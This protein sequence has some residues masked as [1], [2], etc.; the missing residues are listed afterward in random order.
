IETPADAAIRRMR[1]LAGQRTSRRPAIPLHVLAGA[2]AAMLV[3][4]LLVWL[5]VVLRTPDG[6]DAL[7]TEQEVARRLAASGAN[8]VAVVV[9]VRGGTATAD[10]FTWLQTRTAGGVVGW[11]VS[12]AVGG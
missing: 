6:G 12:T 11:V 7:A 9:D 3:V 10:G 4:G 2:A 5:T 1:Q 8:S